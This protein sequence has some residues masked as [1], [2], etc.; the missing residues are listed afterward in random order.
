M[1]AQTVSITWPE[2]GKDYFR[3]FAASNFGID[4]KN[5]LQQQG[6]LMYVDFEWK[7]NTANKTIDVTFFNETHY[8]SMVV[9]KF[10]GTK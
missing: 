5:W 2:D 6:L 10:Q 1:A 9:L 7:V 8:A 3:Q 4:I